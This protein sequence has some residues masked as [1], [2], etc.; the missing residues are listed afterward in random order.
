MDNW[1]INANSQILSK[2]KKNANSQIILTFGVAMDQI[3]QEYLNSNFIIL[4][5]VQ[6]VNIQ[7]PLSLSKKSGK[8]MLIIQIP[9]KK[10][11]NVLSPPISF[12][13]EK[14]QQEWD[15]DQMK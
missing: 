15:G 13:H 11:K 2:K 9:L 7:S 14:R 12:S 10:K 5:F 3:K 6:K 1:Q 4:S 8:K